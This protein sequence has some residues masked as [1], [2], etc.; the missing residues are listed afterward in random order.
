MASGVGS[1]GVLEL[2]E[3]RRSGR[4]TLRHWVEAWVIS[5]RFFALPWAT[6]F[7][8]FGAALAGIRD[9]Q[10]ALAAS[11]VTGLVL[12]AAHFRNN[13]RDVEL[14]VDRY[15]DSVEEARRVIS[16]IKPYTA[17]AWLVPLRIT[18]VRFQKVNEYASLALATA[19]YA[20]YVLPKAPLTL[21]VFALGVFFAE[22]YTD[23]WKR[24][25]LGEI[26]CFMGHGYLST[27]FGYLS[28]GV[29]GLGALLVG[30]APGLIS[31]LTY[32][33]DQYVDL[34]SDFV[35][36]VR[37]LA[38]AWFKS[39]LPLSLYVLVAYTLFI[40]TTHIFVTAGVYPRGV[41][42]VLLTLP[43]VL[44]NA[45]RLEYNR[46]RALRDTALTLVILVPLLMLLGALLRL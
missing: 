43:L 29:V 33:V 18:S 44:V 11:I 2:Y 3:A 40:A 26:A 5:A 6:A 10:A 36:R 31:G 45:P 14:G 41:L 28:Q 19:L 46:E 15:V 4:F 21:P 32:S 8:L 23:I 9:W 7:C 37:N 13:Y 22:T 38:E 1:L 16:T 25:G 17:A 42:L 34:K 30:V 20:L 35:V 12:L 27:L 24:R 39:E